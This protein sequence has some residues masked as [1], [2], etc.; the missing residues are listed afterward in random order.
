MAASRQMVPG[1][2]TEYGRAS[3]GANAV[4]WRLS[5]QSYRWLRSG[6]ECSPNKRK[7]RHLQYVYGPSEDGETLQLVTNSEQKSSW[8]PLPC[9]FW[10]H[11]PLGG[12]DSQLVSKEN[13]AAERHSGSL[14]DFGHPQQSRPRSSFFRAMRSNPRQPARLCRSGHSGGRNR[15]GG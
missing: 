3:R 2:R 13:C 1:P 6:Q 7:S 14:C 12:L 11:T 9:G 8:R 15:H 4:G 5:K 10:D